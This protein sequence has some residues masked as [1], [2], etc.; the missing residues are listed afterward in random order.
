MLQMR[1]RTTRTEQS[2]ELIH[3]LRLR[4]VRRVISCNHVD[5][6]VANCRVQRLDIVAVA[7]RRVHLRVRPPGQRGVFIEGEMM[8]RD[9][10]RDLRAMPPRGADEF[11]RLSR[12]YMCDVN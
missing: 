11:E 5:G 3:V 8:R 9:F 12:G 10:A 6:T 7:Q 1:R 4:I 2:A